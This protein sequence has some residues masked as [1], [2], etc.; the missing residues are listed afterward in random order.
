MRRTSGAVALGAAALVQVGA[1]LAQQQSDMT[2]MMDM[3]DAAAF[4]KL[5]A[6]QFEYRAGDGAEGPAWDVRGWYG[7][8]YDKL[9]FKTEGIRLD[10]VTQDARVELLW[11]RIFSRWWSTQLGVR[12]DFGDGPSRNWLA[13]GVEGLAPYFFQTEA[14][15]YL[16]DAGRT[17]AR[18]RVQSDLLLAQRVV[19]QPELELNVYGQDDPE[20]HIGAGFS[21]LQLGLRLRY[22]IRRECAPYVGIAWL[23]RLGKTAELVRA[24]GEEPSVLQLVA[25]IRFW[26]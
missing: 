17:A 8:D 1:A 6:E 23:H 24:A 3:N 26:L 9:W 21:D 15:G 19:L 11:D 10:S 18:F 25:G 20:R 22:E 14:T 4:G 5:L 2:R 7:T 12:H 13:L 16:G